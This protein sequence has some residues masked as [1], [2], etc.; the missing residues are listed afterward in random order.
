MAGSFPCCLGQGNRHADEVDVVE[1]PIGIVRTETPASLLARLRRLGG[2]LTIRVLV[3]RFQ[4]WRTAVVRGEGTRL[5]KCGLNSGQDILPVVGSKRIAG[6]VLSSHFAAHVYFGFCAVLS[7][8][9][10]A[11]LPF[12][13]Q[14]H[15]V[16]S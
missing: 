15:T 14:S 2:P 7:R 16:A 4:P 11:T 3:N 12:H 9:P 1:L 13:F 6:L 8:S 5:P 10:T